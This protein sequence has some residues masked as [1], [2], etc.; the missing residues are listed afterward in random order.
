MSQW[1]LIVVVDCA[2]IAMIT[3][4]ASEVH[5]SHTGSA[6]ICSA[7]LSIVA[8]SRAIHPL[9]SSTA[10]SGPAPHSS[11]Y[12]HYCKSSVCLNKILHFSHPRPKIGPG[13]VFNFLDLHEKHLVHQNDHQNDSLAIFSAPGPQVAVFGP[14]NDWTE[15]HNFTVVHQ[16]L[17][18]KQWKRC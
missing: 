13:S 18:R 6:A 7:T 2:S 10:L 14:T 5:Q 4:A 12:T 16:I 11:S 17:P 1:L 15:N 8:R 9:D 3:P